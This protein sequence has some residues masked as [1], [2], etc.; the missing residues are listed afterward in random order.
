MSQYAQEHLISN[1]DLHAGVRSYQVA[2]IGPTLATSAERSSP[3]TSDGSFSSYPQ[4]FDTTLQ[5]QQGPYVQQLGA[6]YLPAQNSFVGPY[7]G[8]RQLTVRWRA[9]SSL[10][11]DGLEATFRARFALID[12]RAILTSN[13][14][15]LSEEMKKHVEGI[16]SSLRNLGSYVEGKPSLRAQHTTGQ[17]QVWWHNSVKQAAATLGAALS[18]WTRQYGLPNVS[19]EIEQAEDSGNDTWVQPSAGHGQ[20]ARQWPRIQFDHQ[21]QILARG[22]G[23]RQHLLH[24]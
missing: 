4:A 8:Q 19:I 5:G 6:D 9:H 16:A 15:D 12:P 7:D 10:A 17:R 1:E 23:S 13:G 14:I 11:T 20:P 3:F 21:E 24:Q 22:E 2:P 18:L